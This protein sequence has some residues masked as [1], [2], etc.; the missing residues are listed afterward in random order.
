MLTPAPFTSI[1]IHIELYTYNVVP[2]LARSATARADF[3]F[4][5]VF[6][7]AFHPKKVE[8]K[9]GFLMQVRGLNT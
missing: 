3:L 6:L 5:D 7:W 9:Q 8:V 1:N 2:V 4:R